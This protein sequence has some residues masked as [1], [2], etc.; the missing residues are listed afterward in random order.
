[1]L[2]DGLEVVE[3][4]GGCFVENTLQLFK[5]TDRRLR[6]RG[7]SVLRANL[8]RPLRS[9]PWLGSAFRSIQLI[10]VRQNGTRAIGVQR[11][12]CH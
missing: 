12:R 9:L 3:R 1:M 2:L 4:C 8:W 5:F 6:R 7:R 11:G 10:G